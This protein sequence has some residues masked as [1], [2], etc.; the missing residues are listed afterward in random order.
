MH[1]AFAMI[2]IFALAG[3]GFE[4]Q[5]GRFLDLQKERI[6]VAVPAQKCDIATGAD[7]ADSDN[8]LGEVDKLVPV[9]QLPQIIADRG[10]VVM[11]IVGS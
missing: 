1:D 6:L 2:A 11:F 5:H 9:Q 3:V 8:L 4:H 7:A 10:A